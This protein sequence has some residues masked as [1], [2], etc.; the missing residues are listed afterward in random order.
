MKVR[1]GNEMERRGGEWDQEMT[2]F[3][4]RTRVP[5][6][7][8]ARI[9]SR[10]LLTATVACLGVSFESFVLVQRTWSQTS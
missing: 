10:L 6:G 5:V 8:Q 1:T 2:A 9:W 4:I 7:V 3:W